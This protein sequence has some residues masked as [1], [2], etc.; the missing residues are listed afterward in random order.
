MGRRSCA[1][2]PATSAVSWLRMP[3]VSSITPAQ[4]RQGEA[5]RS[6]RVS[7]RRAAARAHRAT[8]KVVVAERDNTHT[9]CW[10]RAMPASP[11]GQCNSLG[12]PH[13]GSKGCTVAPRTRGVEAVDAQLLLDDVA[14]L[15]IQH[16]Q[17][18]A[19]GVLLQELLQACGQAGRQAGHPWAPVHGCAAGTCAIA[20]EVVR[21]TAQ[22]LKAG[23]GRAARRRAGGHPPLESLE[24]TR[25]AAACSASVVFSNLLNALSF[26]TCTQQAQQARRGLSGGQRPRRKGWRASSVGTRRGQ[27]ATA[28]AAASARSR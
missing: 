21:A 11:R 27:R 28:A 20:T 25:E 16:R 26:T 4:Q 7:G 1:L 19:L 24:S 22:S 2:S 12:P 18:V 9:L 15:G 17:S 3:R 8:T 14:Q 23:A 5:G 10:Q 6:V 13:G